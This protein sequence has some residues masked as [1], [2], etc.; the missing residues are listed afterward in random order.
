MRYIILG[1]NGFIGI[2]SSADSAPYGVSSNGN[3]TSSVIYT[4]GNTL[5]NLWGAYGKISLDENGERVE[6]PGNE[7]RGIELYAQLTGEEFGFWFFHDYLLL[8][9]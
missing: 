4:T 6:T 7:R 5:N 9:F 8:Q 1:S 2:S 3:S